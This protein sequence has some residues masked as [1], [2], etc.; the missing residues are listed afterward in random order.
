MKLDLKKKLA[1]NALKVGIGRIQFNNNRLDEIKE[2]ITKQ[3]IRDLAADGAIK[4]K[5]ISGR[6]KNVKRKTRRRIGKI[7]VKVKKRKQ[8]Y[9]KITRKLR[10][11]VSE[12]KKQETID[13][14][15]YRE[16]RKKIKNREFKSKRN[17]KQGIEIKGNLK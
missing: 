2:A 3:D 13:N 15:K 17:L 12:L 9:V 16:L 11:Y 10:N 14:E 5:E 8:E 6:R 1:A 7:K 4:I